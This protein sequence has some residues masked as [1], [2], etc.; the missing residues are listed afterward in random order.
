MCHI[1]SGWLVGVCFSMSLVKLK[2]KNSAP[3]CLC[4][5][6]VR[7]IELLS[8]YAYFWGCSLNHIFVLVLFISFLF[9]LKASLWGIFL[10]FPKFSTELS[11]LTESGLQ[12]FKQENF[13]WDA[14]WQYAHSL[15]CGLSCSGRLNQQGWGT[16]LTPKAKFNFWKIL[17]SHCDA[18]LYLNEL[19]IWFGWCN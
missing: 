10:S 9:K 8:E 19:L 3:M 2:V 1:G 14:V 6:W 5:E 18:R 4:L 13:S 12:D 16:L 11:A 15:S 7:G 17:E